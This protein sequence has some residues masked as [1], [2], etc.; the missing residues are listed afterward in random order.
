[1]QNHEQS[2]AA[3]PASELQPVA[4]SRQETVEML[5]EEIELELGLEAL[6]QIGL[7]ASRSAVTGQV[8]RAVGHRGWL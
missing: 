2:Q 5:F 3:S 1:M 7:E 6:F 4:F 8:S